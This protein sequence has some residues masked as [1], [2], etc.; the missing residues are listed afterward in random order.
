MSEMIIDS[1]SY[2]NKDF[3]TI[4]PELL[5]LVRGLTNT[6]DPVNSNESDPG[7]ALLKIQAF[8]ADK[9]NYNIDK[10]VLEN[11]PSSVTQRGNAQKLYEL[12]GYNMKWYKS[13]TTEVT[14]KYAKGENSSDLDIDS[15]TIPKYTQLKD[16]LGE[17]V[18]TLLDN[19]T[20]SV[21]NT[22]TVN[23]QTLNAMEGT[24]HEYLLNGVNLITI[25]NL[26][27]DYRLYFNESQIASNGI[28]IHNSGVDEL[29]QIVDN[30]DATQLGQ[31][32]FKFGVLPNTNT[33]YVQFPQDAAEIFGQGINIGYIIS[34][35]TSGNISANVLT[36]LFSELTIQE[37]S[38]SYEV[39][40]Y[41]RVTNPSS[42]NNGTDPESLAQAYKN[43]QK[44]VGTFNTLVT[45]KDYENAI[46]NEGQ[47]SNC[48]V[49]DRTSDLNNSYKI[50]TKTLGG[51]E[52]KSITTKKT[53][54]LS[55]AGTDGEFITA[56]YNQP[57]MSAFN[58]AVYALNNVKSIYNGTTYNKSFQTSYDA[59]DAA[60]TSIEDYKSVQHDWI[61][62]I[63]EGNV[64]P[65]LFKNLVALY[66]KVFTHQKV[67]DKEAEKIEENINLKLFQTYSSRNVEFGKEITYDGLIDTIMSADT[68]IK[69]VILDDPELTSYVMG[70]NNSSYPLEYRNTSD[71]I[72][73]AQ[74][75]KVRINLLA[76][77]ILAGVTP[78]CTFDT[79]A[80]LSY[81][82]KPTPDYTPSNLMLDTETVNPEYIDTNGNIVKLAN[83]SSILS[84]NKSAISNVAAITTQVKIPLTESGYKLRTNETIHFYAPS[85]VTTTQ[86]STYL[87][88]YLRTT[89][90]VTIQTDGL[91]KLQLNDVLYVTEN[92]KDLLGLLKEGEKY[93]CEKN[94]WIYNYD[95]NNPIIIKPNF[96]LIS[97]QPY[98]VAND[99]TSTK[100][101]EKFNLESVNT[102]DLMEVNKSE[103]NVKKITK[104]GN[105]DYLVK[106][107]MYA[108]W[109]VD[110]IDNQLFREEDWKD[111][112][113]R[114][115]EGNSIPIKKAEHILQA[116][117]LFIYTDSS[118]S[119][120]VLL[121]SGTKLTVKANV[122]SNPE[123]FANS[124][125]CD[126]IS[127]E[128]VQNDGAQADFDWK[129]INQS[130]TFIVQE[131]Q[132]KTIGAGCT[133]KLKSGHTSTLTYLNNT[134]Q[135]IDVPTDIEWIAEGVT[136][137]LP[138]LQFDAGDSD[139]TWTG[140]S[141]LSMVATPATPFTLA[142]YVPGSLTQGSQQ[143]I[144]LF[145]F[146]K[147]INPR[148]Q[149]LE[150]NGYKPVA[151]IGPE[152]SMVT[153]SVTMLTG[154]IQQGT[155]VLQEDDSYADNLIVS[156]YRF[157]DTTDITNP[158]PNLWEVVDHGT[159]K[160]AFKDGTLTFTLI[161]TP[162]DQD[163]TSDS[164]TT[165][166]VQLKLS[167]L[168][169]GSII[170]VALSS[171]DEYTVTINAPELSECRFIDN[172]TK[173]VLDLPTC[174]TGNSSVLKSDNTIHYLYMGEDLINASGEFEL[175]ISVPRPIYSS[176][177]GES[178]S[179]SS[180]TLSFLAP[181]K[182]N[183][184]SPILGTYYGSEGEDILLVTDV[185]KELAQ[186]SSA[187][188]SQD[189]KSEFDYTYQIDE[190]DLI[191]NPLDPSSFYNTNHI[192]NKY[193]ISQLDINNI[194][195]K[196]AKQSKH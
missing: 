67:S 134:E 187:I 147:Y 72:M 23:V 2:T 21:N 41:T 148:T 110:N 91:Y 157:N 29:W 192:Y 48:V 144:A 24:Y 101:I 59:Q 55:I 84:S 171:L 14:F 78:W 18:Y 120:L 71:N 173:N 73:S 54:N 169:L 124:W 151:L 13:A 100:E 175:I 88:A 33:C 12:V 17:V 80:Q 158:N 81:A 190:E 45:L 184:L 195:I 136:Y 51:D 104:N 153:S 62:V 154:G 152:Q 58:I 32:V 131:M 188:N 118:K 105:Q 49:S 43:Y 129:P 122:S 132:I 99:A 98:S 83:S 170:P 113:D 135:T 11:F 112:Y 128:E 196:V 35:G 86:L 161:P 156:I 39:S 63:N 172:I 76:K 141:R 130:C 160:Q 181:N 107:D 177:E 37:G 180:L 28:F 111:S 3:R 19:A 143:T 165:M 1:T 174:D 142:S 15:Y 106:Q 31:K 79:S 178:P 26:D 163:N 164:V 95:S 4:F 75:A 47:V 185:V 46:Y 87:Y 61:D 102:I 27:A 94:T 117:E 20:I 53:V 22:E 66:G 162:K 119:E 186:I 96:D 25:N 179:E 90:P 155:L 42:C 7:V 127:L 126:S 109:I 69:M 121:Q 9:L 89:N 57:T 5:E 114:D 8:I 140:F 149:K 82:L 194:N 115:S 30:L 116:N 183:K 191:S 92:A 56:E 10:N 125:T 40:K 34:S 93:P 16:D 65:Y 168:F 133:I 70:S 150:V 68:R 85:Y 193:I 50:R 166:T 138:Q 38:N 145:Q 182:I 97:N 6:W 176:E 137:S 44:T 64:F 139:H 159:V 52:L 103:I 123:Y 108:V 146:N 77:S 167:S 189:K 74:L 60:K 36:Q